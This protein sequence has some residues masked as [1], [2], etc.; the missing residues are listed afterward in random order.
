MIKLKIVQLK[1]IEGLG[2][3][4][5][6]NLSEETF[7]N[8]AK[9]FE[10]KHKNSECEIHKSKGFGNVTLNAKKGK[11]ELGLFCCDDFK[12]IINDSLKKS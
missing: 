4:I 10:I 2:S 3:E 8:I 9:D 1:P 5:I 7:K 11:I 6:N 12:K